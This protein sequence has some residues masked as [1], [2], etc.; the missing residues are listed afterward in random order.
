MNRSAELKRTAFVTT[1]PR[2]GSRRWY[3]DKLDAAVRRIVK[4]QEPGCITCDEVDP[5]ELECSH[6]FRRGFE[7][8]RFDVAPDGNNHTQCRLC[9]R[10]HGKDRRPY[11]GWFLKRFGPVRGPAIIKSLDERAHSDRQFTPIE[12]EELLRDVTEK[13]KALTA[14]KRA[15]AVFMSR[16]YDD[17]DLPF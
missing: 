4:L 5:R 13:L 6:F 11:E 14:T 15:A 10:K 16:P 3:V 12:L 2:K 8:T 9:N 7:P 1:K 17:N